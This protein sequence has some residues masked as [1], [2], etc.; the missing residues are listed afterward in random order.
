MCI[1]KYIK[2]IVRAIIMNIAKKIYSI[3]L[4]MDILRQGKK[5]IKGGK[6]GHIRYLLQV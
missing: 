3:E 1:V 6:A 4:M 5:L 2:G